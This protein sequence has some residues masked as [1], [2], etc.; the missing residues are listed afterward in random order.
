MKTIT[1]FLTLLFVIAMS[2]TSTQKTV[3]DTTAVHQQGAPIIVDGK[4]FTGDRSTLLSL[5]DKQFISQPE[6]TSFVRLIAL[7]KG[8]KVDLLEKKSRKRTVTTFQKNEDGLWVAI[9]DSLVQ[10]PKIPL[11]ETVNATGVA[12][13]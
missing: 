9:S 1:L 13:N 6:D 12:K 10:V 2:C 5:Y 8:A 11:G 7:R 3:V 4:S